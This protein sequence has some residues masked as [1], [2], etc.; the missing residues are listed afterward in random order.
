MKAKEV[1][2]IGQM[3]ALKVL[4]GERPERAAVIALN[5]MKLRLDK[6]KREAA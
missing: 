2:K 3:N 4:A 5:A 6:A 1:S